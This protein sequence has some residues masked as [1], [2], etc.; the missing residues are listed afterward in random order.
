LPYWFYCARARVGQ[1]Q[2]WEPDP[3]LSSSGK[4]QAGASLLKLRVESRV[5]FRIL[6]RFLR[7][8][9]ARLAY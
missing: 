5:S 1:S 6:S 7:T 9:H 3:A 8:R 2:L 4:R